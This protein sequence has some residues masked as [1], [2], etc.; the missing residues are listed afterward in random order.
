MSMTIEYGLIEFTATSGMMQGELTSDSDGSI[1]DGLHYFP[2]IMRVS[3]PCLL[4]L[5]LRQI[6]SAQYLATFRHKR[7][8]LRTATSISSSFPAAARKSIR[9]F[10]WTIWIKPRPNWACFMRPTAGPWSMPKASARNAPQ[11][12]CNRLP[13]A[14][15]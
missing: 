2:L 13:S 6:S 11:N 7:W 4:A 15:R 9:V 5:Q 14:P 10:F 8:G 3:V 1:F 12:C